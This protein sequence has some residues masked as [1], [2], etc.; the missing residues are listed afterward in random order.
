MATVVAPR[1]YY[2]HEG[3][4]IG[5]AAVSSV[6]AAAAGFPVDGLIDDR[7]GTLFKFTSSGAGSYVQFDRGAAARPPADALILPA[8]HDVTGTLTVQTDDDVAFLSP[9]TRVSAVTVTSQ[10]L[11]QVFAYSGSDT[12]RYTR[13]IFDATGTWELPQLVITELNSLTD[14]PDP[15]NWVD[16]FEDATQAFS[17]RSGGVAT[18]SLGPLRRRF[19]FDFRFQTTDE[20]L[21]LA[22]FADVTTALVFWFLPPWSDEVVLPVRFE[23]APARRLDVSSPVGEGDVY[24]RRVVIVEHIL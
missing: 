19:E 5:A 6:P 23:V 18:L 1:I 22:A 16:T 20:A 7:L 9:T 11:P 24:Q 17:L 12:E 14:G 8:G 21:W 4:R 2:L 13:V 10:T 3:R 15:G